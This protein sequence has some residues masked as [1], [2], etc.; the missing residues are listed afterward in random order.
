QYMHAEAHRFAQHY[1]DSLRR[2]TQLEEEVA[3]GGRAP[4][5][6][7]KKDPA[8]IAKEQMLTS[9]QEMPHSTHASLPVLQPRAH[10]EPAID[11]IDVEDAAAVSPPR[12]TAPPQG[13]QATHITPPATEGLPVLGNLKADV[14][15]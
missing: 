2:K 1:T 6:K 5:R 3:Q 15:D 9:P 11:P 4:R 13:V 7:T 12:T 10:D 8:S 14:S